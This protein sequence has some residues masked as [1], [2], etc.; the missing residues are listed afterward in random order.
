MGTTSLSRK[1]QN[2]GKKMNNLE[3][4][5]QKYF[6]GFLFFLSL[7][8]LINPLKALELSPYA[9]GP[10]LEIITQMPEGTWK[11]VNANS[12]SEVW[13]LPEL[14]PLNLSSNPPPS[15]LISA[16][17]S[18]AWDSNRGDLILYGG[19]HANYSGNDVYRWR[20]RDLKWERASLPSQVTV[21]A[22]TAAST[23]IDGV[24]A[25]PAS[26]HTYD[27]SIFL[28]TID[29]YLVLGGALYNT[30]GPYIRQS[31][32]DP[33]VTRITGP[34]LFDPEKAAANQVGGTTGSHVQRVYAFPE[35]TGGEMWQNRDIH[36]NLA[37]SI[38]PKHHVNG[39]TAYANESGVDTVYISASGSIHGT[40]QSLFRYQITDVN[41]PWTDKIDRVGIYWGAPS[42][43]PACG[44]D[45]DTKIFLKTTGV[46]TKPLYFWDLRPD[47]TTNK[48]QAVVVE[49]SIS[50]LVQWLN[51]YTA[52]TGKSLRHCA[53]DFDPNRKNFL[54]WC[55][56]AEVWRITPPSPLSTFGW[57]A[58]MGPVIPSAEFPLLNVGTGILGK[59]DYIPGFDVFMGLENETAGNVWVYK[60]IGWVTPDPD[61]NNGGGGGGINQLP[62]ILLTSPINNQTIGIGTPVT[63]STVADDS[64]GSIVE[65]KFFA[66]NVLV[67][68]LTTEP[69]STEWIPPQA[70][71][72]IIKA[73]A[74]DNLGAKVTST[75]ITINIVPNTPLTTT[76]LQRDS[77]GTIST[78]D[79]YL[80][81]Y[82]PSA[83]FGSSQNLYLSGKNYVPLIKFNIF[84]HEG[85]PIPDNAIIESATLHLYKGSSYSILASLHAMNK[86]WN[87][88]EATWAKA[89]SSLSWN[90][91]GAAAAGLDYIAI[92]DAQ[93]NLPWNAGIWVPFDVTQRVKT[94]STGSAN[95]GWRLLFNSGDSVNNIRFNSSEKSPELDKRP[96]LEIKWRI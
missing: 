70:G 61:G 7:W 83:N 42:D 19:G 73:E 34:Y 29:R 11:K 54:L 93:V 69:Y 46:N 52:S 72:Y 55:G 50:N 28:P 21:I 35:I 22:G 37:T 1:Q 92:A 13:T 27:N 40:G 76:L 94:F 65:I 5:K 60:P 71:E 45:S 62:T 77:E 25:A 47:R 63:L 43:Q 95:Y 15:K 2:K 14:R 66:N 91:L 51:N 33:T 96:K 67:D 87:E 74:F 85:G 31:E 57:K 80:S 82:H 30:G 79:T 24:D 16:W 81:A 48:D 49:G 44:Y 59:W 78:A 90:A 10:L 84:S 26:A 88:K 64:D 75:P 6:R 3:K 86:L 12:F 68:S 56:T 53:L 9:E 4:D 32:T 18:F 17:S 23:A 36:K 38:L 89:S 58:E 41:S 8:L 39:C 20:S